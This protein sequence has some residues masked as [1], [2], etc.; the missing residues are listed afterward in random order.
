M[1]TF[2]WFPE[3]I[4]LFS[5]FYFFIF[6]NA[7]NVSLVWEMFNQDKK[8]GDDKVEK[9]STDDPNVNDLISEVCGTFEEI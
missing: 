4:V 7:D 5:G 2:L 1:Q 6:F 8:N 9:K 3:E